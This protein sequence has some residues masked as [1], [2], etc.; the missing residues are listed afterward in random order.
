[1]NTALDRVQELERARGRDSWLAARKSAASLMFKLSGVQPGGMESTQTDAP[2]LRETPGGWLA[3]AVDSPRIA[4][5]AD[6]RDEALAKFRAER[7]EWR[8]LI[9]QARQEH[10]TDAG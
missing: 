3:V 2:D 5:I 6:T 9:A 1:V 10:A 8:E 7:A 4:V